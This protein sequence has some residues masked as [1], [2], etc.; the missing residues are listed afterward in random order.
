[1]DWINAFY[2]V[3]IFLALYATVFQLLLFFRYRKK[4]GEKPKPPKKLP[5]VS[6]IIPAYNEQA[7]I[8]R[9]I[10]NVLSLNY[11]KEKLEIIVVDDGSTDK[12]YEK[13][14]QFAKLGIKVFTKP[15]G[16]KA[17]ALNFGLKH[18]KGEIVGVVDCDTTLEKD[19]LLRAVAYFDSPKV[20]SVTSR[21]LQRKK[22]A[23]RERWLDIE[24][25][26]TAY[27]RKLSEYLNIITATPGPLSLYR[28]KVLLKV[29]G[30][31]EKS[32]LEDNEIAWRLIYHGYRIKMAYDSKTY[33]N[34]EYKLKRWWKQRTRW[35]IGGLQIVQKY[36][37]LLFKHHPI[38][39]YLLPSW[40][41]GYALTSLGILIWFYL[42][43]YSFALN[44]EYWI[45][46][47]ALGGFPFIISP[48]NIKIDLF[49]FY[50]LLL[51]F[52]SLSFL[53]SAIAGYRKKPS[54]LDI[55]TFIFIYLPLY[56]FL[57]L[58][59]VFK[60]FKLRKRLRL[61]PIWLTK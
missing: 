6:L 49:L 39:T 4:V 37:P 14:K 1:M 35:S 31:D 57:Q 56:S 60:F 36:L 12:T 13:A 17:S 21:I 23:L 48:V 3:V 32:I 15:N 52:I 50:G 27:L 47:L 5:T 51:F 25:K 24:L 10:K 40:I 26:L 53:I 41:I 2:L 22:K 30:F 43:V 33:T 8:A 45:R 55:L 46:T 28:R 29:G 61:K 16:G 20:A 19:A 58:Y 18:A 44:V 11:P 59:S 38:G 34:L 9:T 7:T 42:F 54:W